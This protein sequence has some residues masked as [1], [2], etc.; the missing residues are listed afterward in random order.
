M[1]K[2]MISASAAAALALSVN[3]AA[4][5]C[6]NPESLSAPS[7]PSGRMAEYT[8]MKEARSQVINYIEKKKDHLECVTSRSVQNMMIN[9]I[10]RVANSYNIELRKF[11]SLHG[12]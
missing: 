7:I 8:E 6:G 3:V 12:I 11:N 2:L 9:R 1:F 5:D 10:H 4:G